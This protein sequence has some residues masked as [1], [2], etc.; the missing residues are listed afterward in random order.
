MSSLAEAESWCAANPVCAGFTARTAPDAATGRYRTYF[1]RGYSALNT[2]ANWTSYVKA[3]DAPA[4]AGAQQVWAKP[5]PGG[6]V[7]V[8][9]INGGGAGGKASMSQRI[10]LRYTHSARRR[11]HCPA[12]QHFRPRCGRARPD[13]GDLLLLS[14]LR[15]LTVQRSVAARGCC[16]RPRTIGLPAAA[17]PG[18]LHVRDIWARKDAAVL[19]AGATSFDPPPV[20]PRAS[21]F[22]LLSPTQGPQ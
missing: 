11:S 3:A 4:S 13:L 1:K 17:G 19:K 5:Q 15:L 22:W 7:A 8:I 18:G 10:P 6:A 14:S 21:S 12:Q 20:P 9:L 2:D 16:W